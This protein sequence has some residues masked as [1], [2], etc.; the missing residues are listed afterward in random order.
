MQS[1]SEQTPSGRIVVGVDDSPGTQAALRW[2][3]AAARTRDARL[4]LIAAFDLPTP[5]ASVGWSYSS[6][7]EELPEWEASTRTSAG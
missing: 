1:G 7:H 2:A 6:T 3:S 5:Y 4:D